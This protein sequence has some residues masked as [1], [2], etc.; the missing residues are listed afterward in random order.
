LKLTGLK[1]GLL[2]NFDTA[3][4]IDGV[5]RLVNGDLDT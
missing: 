4:L 1:L 2:M 5:K 3:R